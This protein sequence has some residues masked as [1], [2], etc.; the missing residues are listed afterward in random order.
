MKFVE[1]FVFGECEIYT[2]EIRYKMRL[3][4]CICTGEGNIWGVQRG[5]GS[6]SSNRGG[7]HSCWQGDFKE[8]QRSPLSG[9]F[10]EDR[11]LL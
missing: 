10:R 2:S 1:F 9:V 7:Q 5:L 4:V 6:G 8:E 3:P 11:V